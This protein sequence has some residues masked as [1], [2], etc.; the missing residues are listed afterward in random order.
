MD[1]SPVRIPHTPIPPLFVVELRLDEG[2]FA[3]NVYPDTD[4]KDTTREFCLQHNL[5][6][7]KAEKIL[8][9]LQQEV[10]NS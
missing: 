4:L 5:G 8:Q 2:L 6:A 7:D 3:I 10:E 1:E 9:I